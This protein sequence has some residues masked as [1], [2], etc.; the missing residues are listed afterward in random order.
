LSMRDALGPAGRE[1][2]KLPDGIVALL[3]DETI[4]LR[5]ALAEHDAA[6]AVAM[7]GTAPRGAAQEERRAALAARDLACEGL[8]AALGEGRRRA[9]EAAAGASEDPAK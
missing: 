5:R 7:T 4:A 6:V 9:I 2:L 3:V 8:S 1:Q